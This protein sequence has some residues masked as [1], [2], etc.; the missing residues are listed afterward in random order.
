MLEYSSERRTKLILIDYIINFIYL[1]AKRWENVIGRPE[2]QK[3]VGAL[4][5]KHAKKGIFITTSDFT[6]DALDYVNYIENKIVLINGHQ[7]AS[8]MIEY[9]LGVATA[10]VFEIKEIDKN[11]FENN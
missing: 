5:G 9:N 8:Y 4:H 10:E 7:L 1:Q 11:Y 3:F 2:I 6:K